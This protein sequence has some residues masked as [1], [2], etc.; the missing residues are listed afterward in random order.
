MLKLLEM[1][2]FTTGGRDSGRCAGAGAAWRGGG[3]FCALPRLDCPKA[4]A[5]S[6][7][8]HRIGKRRQK[9]MKASLPPLGAK[10]K[11]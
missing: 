3:T 7:R 8:A 5:V 2:G 1:G 11:R 4:G 10:V 9:R 6:A